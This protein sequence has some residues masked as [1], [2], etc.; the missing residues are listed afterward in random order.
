MIK[1]YKLA[2]PYGCF[3]NFHRSPIDVGGVTYATTEHYFQAMKFTDADHRERVRNCKTP[4]GAAKLGRTPHES[5]RPD[6]DQVKDDVMYTA[7]WAKFAQHPDLAEILL[8]TGDEVIVE[9][10]SNDSYWADGGDGSGRNQLGLTLMKVRERMV[11]ALGRGG[12]S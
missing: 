2:E 5:Y 8:S 11:D 12:R 1:F 3:S 7:V 9:H 4:S 6:W 10:T